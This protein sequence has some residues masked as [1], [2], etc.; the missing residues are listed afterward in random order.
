MPT[1]HEQIQQQNNVMS[2]IVQPIKFGICV[3][4]Q[5]IF[6]NKKIKNDSKTIEKSSIIQ[7]LHNMYKYFNGSDK[8]I[9]EKSK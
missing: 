4:E 9:A 6:D 1:Q 2:K 3:F 5:K 7:E 8:K